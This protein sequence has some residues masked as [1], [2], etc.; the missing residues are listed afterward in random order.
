VRWSIFH[1][2]LKRCT[3]PALIRCGY[4]AKYTYIYTKCFKKAVAL[5]IA[6]LTQI[7]SL[8]FIRYVK[9]NHHLTLNLKPD[10]KKQ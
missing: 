3:N 9:T 1:L 2:L 6:K 4:A 8:Q 5:K 10:P 7:C